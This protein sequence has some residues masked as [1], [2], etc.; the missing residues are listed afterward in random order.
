[1]KTLRFTTH[2]TTE[3]VD[4][5]V[6]FLGEFQSL[7]WEHYGD[8]IVEMHKAIRGEHKK[9]EESGEFDDEILF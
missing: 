7:V 6:Q 4:C 3:E 9:A 1:M 8:E 2:W 5:I